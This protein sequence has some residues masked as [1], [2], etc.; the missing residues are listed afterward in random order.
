MKEL[1]NGFLDSKEPNSQMQSEFHIDVQLGTLEQK[2]EQIDEEI[3]LVEDKL[4]EIRRFLKISCITY[5]S[6]C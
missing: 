4:N 3:R 6:F 5:V 2:R 1:E